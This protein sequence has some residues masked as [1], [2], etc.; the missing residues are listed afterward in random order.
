MAKPDSSRNTDVPATI[1]G[2][3]CQIVIACAEICKEDV[4][5]VGIETGADV[6]VIDKE[7]KKTCIESKLH[8]KKFGRF[9]DDIIKTIYNFYNDYKE[10]EQIAKMSFV[11][12]V[13][14]L[15]RDKAFFDEWGNAYDEE[16]RY[17]REAVLRK[18]IE[19]HKECKENYMQFCKKMKA[20]GVSD[21]DCKNILYEKIFD[22]KG[23]YPY[24]DYAVEN[25]ECSYKEFIDKIEFKFYD[26]EKLQL[27]EE[28]EMKAQKKIE[29]DYLLISE[30][31]GDE[32][33]SKEA[34]KQ[35]FCSLVKLFFDCICEN[36][37]RGT[38]NNISVS[39]YKKCLK[40]YNKNKTISE[41]AGKIKRIL[42][43]LAYD[44][45]QLIDELELETE[46]DCK[47]LECYSKVKQLFLMKIHDEKGDLEFMQRY[48]LKESMYS[49]ENEIGNAMIGLIRMLAIILY[50]KRIEVKD[51]KLFFDN[52]LDNLEINN[53]LLCCHKRAYGKTGIGNIV[54][55]LVRNF[56]VFGSATTNQ[57]I[58]TD[59]NYPT[60]E[61]PCDIE[62]L[63]REVYD[64]TQTDENYKDYKFLCSINYKCPNCLKKG[65][66]TC[67]KFWKGGGG[68]CKGI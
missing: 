18:S 65:G 9:S 12:N 38:R 1:A 13:G 29:Q 37:Q 22:S 16:V 8:S 63:P 14:I 39:Q 64:I 34:A 44:E 42:G 30:D 57:V 41:E 7:S 33:L 68:L 21:K 4:R 5:E 47:Y 50:E 17:I 67:E 49:Q 55:E 32:S 45:E 56:D 46:E 31:I 61:R 3:Y 40:D 51:V 28:L 2:F 23:I 48:L 35:I 24:A 52:K 59:S 62:E 11:T 10:S 15:L 27:L 60:D 20:K 43:M 25:E 19:L 26:K 36:T 58:V 54:R 6:V 66:S 53:I